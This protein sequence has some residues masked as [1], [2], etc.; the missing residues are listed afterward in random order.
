MP[1]TEP[2]VYA[3]TFEY[4]YGNNTKG[5][6]SPDDA[7]GISGPL[8]EDEDDAQAAL[9]AQERDGVWGDFTNSEANDGWSD[10]GFI[11]AIS[12]QTIVPSSKR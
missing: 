7:G 2:T 3:I 5:T 6:Q 9:K 11:L 4:S 8:Y 10:E 12:K 1:S